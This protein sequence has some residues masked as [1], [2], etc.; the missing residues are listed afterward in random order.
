MEFCGYEEEKMLE[1]VTTDGKN[2]DFMEISTTG[3]YSITLKNDSSRTITTN[4]KN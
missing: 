2:K 1:Y 4:N 3:M